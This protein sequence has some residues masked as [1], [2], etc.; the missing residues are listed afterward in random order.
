MDNDQD[1]G[2]NCDFIEEPPDDLT[3]PICLLPPRKPHLI[4]CCGHKLCHSCISRVQQAGDPCPCCRKEQFDIMLEKMMERKV[5]DLKVY[6]KYKS[7]GCSWTGELRDLEGHLTSCFETVIDKQAQEV[8]QLKKKNE[9]LLSVIQGMQGLLSKK[10]DKEKEMKNK[11]ERKIKTLN[12]E[13]EQLKEQLHKL[14]QQS[15]QL[16]R[17]TTK[18]QESKAD[19][20]EKELEELRFKLDK[21]TA[22]K[23]ETIERLKDEIESLNKKIFSL[24]TEIGETHVRVSNDE[25]AMRRTIERLNE[26]LKQ[27]SAQLPHQYTT[28]VPDTVLEEL[29]CKYDRRV[30]EKNEIIDNQNEEIKHQQEEIFLLKREIRK[31]E[32]KVTKL[33]QDGR[34]MNRNIEKLN[35]ENKKLKSKVQ[36]LKEQATTTE[37]S[38]SDTYTYSHNDSTHIPP[39]SYHEDTLQCPMCNMTF[40]AVT[41]QRNFELH[42]NTHFH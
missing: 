38:P 40:P 24:K 12:E 21:K 29:Q 27:Q 33:T 15:T 20:L 5:L 22:E 42:V 4:S 26:Q 16:P 1:G 35:E 30:A 14:N 2:F 23:N 19:K 36:D 31:L 13:N 8:E 3:C 10:N 41:S 6:C 28:T 17:H 11:M 25:R 39:A 34:G 18:A 9:E 32:E 37:S 7:K